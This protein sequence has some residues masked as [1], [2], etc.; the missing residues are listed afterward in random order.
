[1]KTNR[2]TIGTK[3][4]VKIDKSLNK[5]A[6]M[7]LF[8]KKFDESTAALLRTNHLSKLFH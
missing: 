4:V 1:M 8:K 5:Y 7:D 3:S 6:K 2:V